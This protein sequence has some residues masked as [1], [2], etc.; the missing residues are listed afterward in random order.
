MK[1]DVSEVIVVD[2]ISIMELVGSEEGKQ[3]R[4]RRPLAKLK[5]A[6]D[7]LLEMVMERARRDKA[8]VVVAFGKVDGWWRTEEAK[9]E[10]PA[11][12]D[13]KEFA[14]VLK[15][16]VRETGCGAIEVSEVDSEDGKERDTNSA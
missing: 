11:D 7:V 5:P 1:A 4:K 15:R 8:A 13:A 10:E 2:S 12:V 6:V 9:E 14:A 3:T 16:W